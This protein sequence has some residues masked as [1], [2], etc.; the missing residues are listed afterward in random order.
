MDELLALFKKYKIEIQEI[1]VGDEVKLERFGI[2]MPF[3]QRE[4]IEERPKKVCAKI[5]KTFIQHP[6][7]KAK[8]ALYVQSL[9]KRPLVMETKS[10]TLTIDDKKKLI[11][12]KLIKDGIL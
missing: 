1:G 10:T 7:Y 2:I 11:R 6:E 3:S 8:T 12:E 4:I 9:I 5:L